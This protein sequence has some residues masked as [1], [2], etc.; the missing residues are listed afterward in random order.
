VLRLANASIAVAGASFESMQSDP[1]IRCL[2]LIYDRG[3]SRGMPVWFPAASM[4]S[5]DAD[6]VFSAIPS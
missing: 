6:T 2:S 3:E 4:V 5:G 1:G